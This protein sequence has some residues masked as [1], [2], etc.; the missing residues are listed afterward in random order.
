[1]KTIAH[2]SFLINRTFTSQ[3]KSAAYNNIIFFDGVCNFCNYWVNF[4]LKYNKKQ[5]LYFAALQSDFAKKMLSEYGYQTSS[6]SS[7]VFLK[8]N[9]IFTQSSAALKIAKE[10]SYP[11]KVAYLFYFIPKLIRDFFYNII[12]KYRYRL[13]GKRDQCRIPSA[14]EKGRFYS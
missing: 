4:A 12:A 10:L 6:L 8:D 1:M 14:K 9:K 13:L 3:L 5:N 2:K 11:W 7:V